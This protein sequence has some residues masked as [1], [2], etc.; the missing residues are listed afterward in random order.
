MFAS[1]N[2]DPILRVY[3]C[4]LCVCGVYF[5][6]IMC[7]CV[8]VCLKLKFAC[9][10]SLALIGP[11]VCLIAAASLAVLVVVGVVSS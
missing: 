4:V 3:A 1:L 6:C 5:V 8:C 10:G 11:S 2:Y 9:L 7:V